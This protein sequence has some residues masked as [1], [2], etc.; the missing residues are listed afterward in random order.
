MALDRKRSIKRQGKVHGIESFISTYTT[1]L[2][3][4]AQGSI[5]YACINQE[6]KCVMLQRHPK[7]EAFSVHSV[8]VKTLKTIKHLSH[9][10]SEICAFAFFPLSNIN[11]IDVVK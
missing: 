9:T 7:A 8:C 4:R 5:I 10:K 1:V 2:K 11:G 6:L 3:K